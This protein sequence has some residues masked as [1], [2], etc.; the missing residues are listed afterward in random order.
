[1]R[2]C[3]ALL[4][5]NGNLRAVLLFVVLV[6]CFLPMFGFAQGPAPDNNAGFKTVDA[7]VEKAVAEGN[8][9]GAVLLVGHNG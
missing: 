7:I 3:A 1:M 6:A 4:V 9:P 8:I 2:G 5:T